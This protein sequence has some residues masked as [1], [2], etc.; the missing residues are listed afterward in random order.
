MGLFQKIYKHGGGNGGQG[1]DMKFPGAIKKTVCG[2]S[3]A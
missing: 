1:E 2:I 3:G